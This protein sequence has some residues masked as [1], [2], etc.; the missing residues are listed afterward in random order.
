MRQ[1]VVYMMASA[2]G[3]ALYIGITTDLGRRLIEHRSG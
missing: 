1:P 2:T 3:R